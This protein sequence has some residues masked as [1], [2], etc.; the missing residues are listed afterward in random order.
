[1]VP[2]SMSLLPISIPRVTN[3]RQFYENPLDFL[4]QARASLGDMIVIRDGGPMFSRAPDC[5]GVIAV[6][7]SVY[8]RAVLSNIDVF[9]MPVSAAQ[10]L[11]LPQNLI[12]L[13]FGV[14]SMR[15]E[16]HAQH[17]RLL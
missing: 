6:F 9:G 3:I 7:G 11:S 15:G 4:V 17:Q 1:M 10:C 16:R 12:N 13:N 5:A 14:H 8:N 2:H